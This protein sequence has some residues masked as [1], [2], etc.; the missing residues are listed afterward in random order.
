MN[1][2]SVVARGLLLIDNI[3]DTTNGAPAG[4]A[5]L[6]ATGRLR[7]EQS[8]IV[9]GLSVGCHKPDQTA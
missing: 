6:G 3:G 8:R 5:E 4:Y 9:E 7:T 2:P 1:A